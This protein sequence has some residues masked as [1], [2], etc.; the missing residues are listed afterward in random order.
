MKN[1]THIAGH[2]ELLC[3][4]KEDFNIVLKATLAKEWNEILDAIVR[5]EYFENWTEVDRRECCIYSKIK[6]FKRDA[7]VYDA[8]YVDPYVYFILNGQCKVIEELPIIQKSRNGF[9]ST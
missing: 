9:Q 5:F 6:N 2:C 1:S 8:E 4:K 3:L 7:L